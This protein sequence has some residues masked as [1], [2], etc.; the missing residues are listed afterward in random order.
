[1]AEFEQ[2]QLNTPVPGISDGTVSNPDKGPT[3]VPL[4]DASMENVDIEALENNYFT[5]PIGTL[6]PAN[7][8]VNNW[9]ATAQVI[10]QIPISYAPGINQELLPPLPEQNQ[11]TKVANIAEQNRRSFSN[12]LTRSQNHAPAYFGADPKPVH[13]STKGFNFDKWQGSADFQEV[14]FH[15]F[16]DNEALY[17]V[18]EDFWDRNSRMSDNYSKLYWPAFTSGWRAIGDMLSGERTYLE[19]DYLGAISF[20]DAMR[21][22]GGDWVNNTLLQTG[23]TMG[24]ISS[25]ALEELVLAGVTALSGGNPAVGGAAV[26]R[27]G[28]NVKR[29]FDIPK[30]FSRV[31]NNFGLTRAVSG[32]GA[33]LSSLR[34]AENA[35]DYWRAGLRF[36]AH[37]IAPETAAAWR[38]LNTTK[39]VANG[40]QGFGKGAQYFG[41]FYRDL[42]AVNLAVAES[43]LEGGMVFNEMIDNLYLEERAKLD[44][45]D[46]SME[47]LENVYKHSKEAEFQTVLYNAPVIFLTNKLVIGTALKGFKGL[48]GAMASAAG[49]MGRRVLTYAGVKTGKEA[50]KKG[51]KW[52]LPRVMARG[53]KG[54]MQQ[55]MGAGLLYGRANLAEGFQELYQEGLAV[56][57]K[58]YYTNLH[59]DNVIVGWDAQKASSEWSDSKGRGVDAMMTK[60]GAEIFASGFVMGGLVQMPQHIMFKTVP[61]T[62]HRITNNAEWTAQQEQQEANLDIAVE[63]L[64]EMYDDAAS[65][66][67]R[68]FDMSKLN[69]ATQKHLSEIMF[70]ADQRYS[71][72]EYY[73]AKDASIYS[74]LNS[75]HMTGKAHFFKAQ[76]QDFLELD[77]K[78]LAEAFPEES[79]Q[80]G[81]DKV[82]SRMVASVERIDTTEKAWKELNQELTN[83]F[84]RNKYKP[85]TD[86]YTYEYINEVMYNQFKNMMMFNTQMMK[87]AVERY[88]SVRGDLAKSG[89]SKNIQSK[90]IDLLTN[91]GALV[92]EMSMLEVE[93]EMART[94]EDLEIEMISQSEYKRLY[95]DIAER[96]Q[97]ELDK[98]KAAGKNDYGNVMKVQEK[99]DAEEATLKEREIFESE[100]TTGKTTGKTKE[101]RIEEL[102]KQ[103]EE[104]I[105]NYYKTDEEGASV[106]NPEHNDVSTQ[107]SESWLMQKDKTRAIKYYEALMK[108]DIS[109]QERHD[110]MVKWMKEKNMNMRK[111]LEY[112]EN[113][114]DRID[115]KYDKLIDKVKQEEEAEVVEDTSKEKTEESQTKTRIKSGEEL[116]EDEA[117]LQMAEDERAIYLDKQERLALLKEIFE[118]L[119][120]KENVIKTTDS[121]EVL[122]LIK[123][124][125]NKDD[126]LDEEQKKQEIARRI[127]EYEIKSVEKN[128]GFFDRRKVGKLAPVVQAYIE[129]LSKQEGGDGI[130][131]MTKFEDF[132]K[133]IM[134]YKALNGRSIELNKAIN[135]MIN[136]DHALEMQDRM[137]LG[138]LKAYRENRGKIEG[139][140]RNWIGTQSVNVFLNDLANAGIYP[141]DE[142]MEA[143]LKDPQNSIPRTYRTENGMLTK[144]TDALKY[145]QLNTIRINFKESMESLFKK[146]EKKEEKKAEKET[147]KKEVKSFQD[148]VEEEQV[149]DPV[150]KQE[151]KLDQRIKDAEEMEEGVDD[152]RLRVPSFIKT[153]LNRRHANY[154]R[155]WKL[156][157]TTEDYMEIEQWREQPKIKAIYKA[158]TEIY[159]I[160]ALE[161]STED[162]GEWL[163]KNRTTPQIRKIYHSQ[164][165]LTY[166]D[167]AVKEPKGFQKSTLDKGARETVLLGKGVNIIRKTLV[168]EDG[169][170]RY[171]YDITD[172]YKNSLILKPIEGEDALN[173]AK[174]KQQELINKSTEG[175]SF[176]FEGKA[177][178]HG[179]VI[180]DKEE[181]SWVIISKRDT[182]NGND[183]YITPIE[184]FKKKIKRKKV[185]KTGKFTSEGWTRSS[186]QSIDKKAKEKVSQLRPEE[187]LYISS[188]RKKKKDTNG[189]YKGEDN[190]EDIE[191]KQEADERQQTMLR[192]LEPAELAG[193]TLRISYGPKWAHAEGVT[194]DKKT[195]ADNYGKEYAENV[196]ILKH[197]QEYS[198][199]VLN[200]ETSLG[201]LNGPTS[202]I[203][204]DSMG[205][206]IHPEVI[207]ESQVLKLFRTYGN[208]NITKVTKDVRNHYIQAYYLYEQFNNALRGKGEDAAVDLKLSDLDYVDIKISRGNEAFVEKGTKG[209]KFEDLEYKY[210][211]GESTYWILQY[212]RDYSVTSGGKIKTLD[213]HITNVKRSQRKQYED[214][215]DELTRTRGNQL[216]KLGA[217]VA[218]VQLPNGSYSLI[219]VKAP[220]MSDEKANNIISSIHKQVEKTLDE[221]VTKTKD[222]K[223]K[224]KSTS[225]NH[226]FNDK[227][228]EDLFIANDVGTDVQLNVTPYG[229]LEI[230]LYNKKAFEKKDGKAAIFERK[231]LIKGEELKN[232][233]TARDLINYINKFSIDAKNFAKTQNDT[234][235]IKQ[236]D[237]IKLNLTVNAFKESIPDKGISSKQILTQ[238]LLPAETS[239]EK[240]VRKNIK[241]LMSASDSAGMDSTA[242]RLKTIRR[243]ANEGSANTVEKEVTWV[244]EDAET[245][246]L[247]PEIISNAYENPEAIPSAVIAGIVGKIQSGEGLNPGEANLYDNIA[248]ERIDEALARAEEQETMDESVKEE[249]RKKVNIAKQAAEDYY[250][251]KT[252]EIID[253]LVK[254]G[255]TS[256]QAKG[257]AYLT[258]MNDPVYLSLIEEYEDLN[259]NSALAVIPGVWDG[260]DVEK[261]DNFIA[262][263]KESLPEQLYT[264]VDHLQQIDELGIK[265]KEA[266]YKVGRFLMHGETISELQ[267]EISVG[268]YTPL[269]YHEAFHG[270]FRMLLTDQEI[271]HYLG[272]A[273]KEVR[274]KMTDGGITLTHGV[275]VKNVNDALKEMR[276]VHPKYVEMTRAKLEETLYE[277]YLANQFDNWKMNPQS[278]STE[279]RSLFQKIMDFIKHLLGY[280]REKSINDLFNEIDSGVFRTKATKNN[281]FTRAAES[282]S[283][284]TYRNK[285]VAFAIVNIPTGVITT[286]SVDTRTG[287]ERTMDVTSYIPADDAQRMIFTIGQLF[288]NRR[289]KSSIADSALLDNTISDFVNMYNVADRI[290]FY[291]E[292]EGFI[293]FAPKLKKYHDVLS[294]HHGL[295]KDAVLNYIGAFAV[296]ENENDIEESEEAQEYGLRST[297][298]YSKDQSMVGGWSKLSEWVRQYIGLTTLTE[299]DEYGNEFIN[300]EAPQ[301]LR[302]RVTVPVDFMFVYRG[303]LKSVKNSRN[304]QELIKKMVMFS[305]SDNKH[306]RAFVDKFLK[307]IGLTESEVLSDDWQLGENVKDA[308]KFQRV[309]NAFRL[310]RTT[311]AIVHRDV[312]GGR[313]SGIYYMYEANR[314]DDEHSQTKIWAA[315]FIQKAPRLL[316]DSELQREVIR[317]LDDLI[318]LLEVTSITDR[319]TTEQL[320]KIKN[321]DVSKDDSL[322]GRANYISSVLNEALGMSLRSEYIKYSVTNNIAE[323]DRTNQ[324]Q[325]LYTLNNYIE[326]VDTEAIREIKMSLQKGEH[327]YRDYQELFDEETGESLGFEKGG[328]KGRIRKLAANNAQFDESVGESTFMSADNHKIWSSQVPTFHL[329][330]I[331]EMR[332][333]EWIKKIQD[334]DNFTYDS[335]IK[336]EKFLEAVRRGEIR[337]IR[338]SGHKLA[339]LGMDT[340]EFELGSGNGV[341]YG[342]LSM[343]DFIKN[344]LAMATYTYDKSSPLKKTPVFETKD[345]QKFVMA[346]VPIKILSDAST[347][348]MVVMP[349][350]HMIHQTDEGEIELTDEG[351]DLYMNDI[352]EEYARIQKENDLETKDE[353]TIE[354]F[355]T[356]E[357]RGLQLFNTGN[358]MNIREG[359]IKSTIRVQPPSLA[360]VTI[361]GILEGNQKITLLSKAQSGKV[362]IAVGTTAVVE[363]IKRDKAGGEYV[364]ITNK[365]LSNVEDVDLAR[366]IEDLGTMVYRTRPE[367]RGKKEP[368][369]FT[370][371]K[372]K[373]WTFSWNLVNFVNGKQDFY[374]LRYNTNIE[375]EAGIIDPTAEYNISERTVEELTELRDDAVEREEYELA[376]QLTN[377]LDSRSKPAD[378]TIPFKFKE[379]TN[380]EDPTK[381]EE[382]A[383]I[384]KYNEG[385]EIFLHIQTYPKTPSSSQFD[386]LILHVEGQRIGNMDILYDHSNKIIA[387]KSVDAKYRATSEHKTI[388]NVE[389]LESFRGLGIG[390]SLYKKA[391]TKYGTLRSDISIGPDAFH[392]YE[393]LVKEGYAEKITDIEQIEGNVGTFLLRAPVEQD[394]SN[395]L[396]TLD[397]SVKEEMEERALAGMPWVVASKEPITYTDANGKKITTTLEERVKQKQMQELGDFT[398]MLYEQNVMASLPIDVREGL[399]DVD[400]NGTNGVT[401]STTQETDYLEKLYNIKH[402]NREYNLAQLFFNFSINARKFAKHTT[403]D[404]AMSFTDM[405][406]NLTK[407]AKGEHGGGT[408]FATD[409]IAPELGIHHKNKDINLLTIRD[410]KYQKLYNDIFGT[411]DVGSPGKTADAFA[412]MTTK[413][414]LHTAFG[415]GRLS[416]NQAQL[417]KKISNG[418]KISSSEI[419]GDS[420]FQGGLIL[421]IGIPGSGKSTWINKLRSEGRNVLVISPDAIRAELTD[422]SDQS[423]N[424]LVFKLAHERA[425]TG[426]RQGKLVVFDATNTMQEGPF[427]RT[428]LIE[429]LKKMSGKEFTTYYEMFDVDIAT[430]KE[431]IKN[432]IATGKKRANV[433]EHVVDRMYTQ[434][435]ENK[436]NLSGMIKFDIAHVQN[437]GLKKLD[438]FLNSKKFMYYDGTTYLK[439]SVVAL[440]PELTSVKIDGEWVARIGREEWHDLRLKLE[441][442]EVDTETFS[443]AAF[444]SASKMAKINVVDTKDAFSKKD[445]S[446]MFTTI[447]A[448]H[449][450]RQMINPS[451]KME[452]VDAVQMKHK[453]PSEQIEGKTIKIDNKSY[454]IREV[455]D[456]YH[457]TIQARLS[458]KYFRR[459]NLIFTMESSLNELA[460][461]KEIGKATV[462]LKAFVDYAQNALEASQAKV[463]MLDLFETENGTPK[464]NLNN[465]ITEKQFEKLFLTFFSKG[466]LSERLPGTSLAL[467]PE[468]GF[469]V[470]KKVVELDKETGQPIRW[471]IIRSD[472]WET[473]YRPKGVEI[474]HKEFADE[475]AETFTNGSMKEGDIYLDVLRHDVM[476]YN[477]K[478]E[479]TDVTGSEF[480]MSPHFKSVMDHIKPGDKIPD[481]IAKAFGIRIPS[482]DD[483]SA[484]NLIMVDFLP[485]VYGSTAIF[486]KRL[487]EISGADFDIDKLYTQL[488]EFYHEKGVFKEYGKGENRKQQ[489]VD[490]IRNTITQYGNKK[491]DIFMATEV[492]ADRGDFVSAITERTITSFN[493]EN[494]TE[495]TVEEILESDK[496]VTAFIA[497]E[498]LE[499]SDPLT[500]Q[501]VLKL[502]KRNE[503]IQGGL[504]LIGLPSTLEEYNQYRDEYGREPY[505]AALNNDALDLKYALLG[506]PGKTQAGKGDH[507]AP[508]YQSAVVTPLEEAWDFFESQMPMLS[509]ERKAQEYDPYNLLGQAVAFN[510]NKEFSRGIG[511]IVA[512]NLPLNVLSE[513]NTKL[514]ND[515]YIPVLELNGQPYKTFVKKYAI[516]TETGEEDS[517]LYRKQFAIS[518]LISGI[519]DNANEQLAQKLGIV[520]ESL[521]VLGTL[522]AMGV[523]MNTA[524]VFIN[525]PAINLIYEELGTKGKMEAGFDKRLADRIN[526]IQKTVLKRKATDKETKANPEVSTEEM[527]KFINETKINR[528][529]GSTKA[530]Y[531]KEAKGSNFEVLTNDQ[532][533]FDLAVLEEFQKA[534][535]YTDFVRNVGVMLNIAKGTGQDTAAIEDAYDAAA[536]LGL[537][538]NNKEFSKT[539][540]PFDVRS[541]FNDGKTFQSTYWQILQEI[542]EKVLPKVLLNRT[543]PFLRLRD[544][545][546]NNLNQGRINSEQRR[547]L[548]SE[549]T[550]YL[551]GKAY[552]QWLKFDDTH[553]DQLA[554]LSNGYIYDALGEEFTVISVVDRMRRYLT[555]KGRENYFLN[556]H[557]VAIDTKHEDNKQGF[558][559]LIT[560]NWTQFTD[561]ELNNL[562]SS[563]L[564]LYSDVNTRQDLMHLINYLTV[565]D[566]LRFNSES[567]INVVPASLLQNQLNVVTPV[568]KLFLDSKPSDKLYDRI[569]GATYKELQYELIVGFTEGVNSNKFITQINSK[570]LDQ[571]FVVDAQ[572]AIIPESTININY[573]A[574]E[575]ESNTKLLSNLAERKFKY[576]FK[577][578]TKEYG[579]VEHAFQSL[580]SGEFDQ[581]TYDKYKKKDGYGI[582]IEGKETSESIDPLAL[583]REL[584]ITSFTQN[585]L[586]DKL[587]KM[588]M[589]HSNF[590][591]SQG[592]TVIDR[593]MLDGL[594]MAQTEFVT[595]KESQRYVTRGYVK[596]TAKHASK[597]VNNRTNERLDEGTLRVNTLFELGKNSMFANG[598]PLTGKKL[599]ALNKTKEILE[600]LGIGYTVSDKK[601]RPR[602]NANFPYALTVID[603]DLRGNKEYR[604]YKLEGMIQPGDGTI[605]VDMFDVMN[606]NGE[607]LGVI[608]EYVKYDQLGSRQQKGPAY[609]YGQRPTYKQ[610]RQN[611]EDKAEGWD[612]LVLGIGENIGDGFEEMFDF[613]KRGEDKAF[614]ETDDVTSTD[615][616]Y[617]A[618]EKQGEEQSEDPIESTL[619]TDAEGGFEID[620]RR[621]VDL[622]AI[623]NKTKDTSEQT[624]DSDQY[625]LITEYFTNL[626]G[627][628]K[629]KLMDALDISTINELFTIFEDQN[630]LD[631][632]KQFIDRLKSCY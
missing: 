255:Q 78:A 92:K 261:I 301:H 465:P 268:K 259:S 146:E 213:R 33:L 12:M 586:N 562:Q 298:Q 542:N 331:A 81:V 43:K 448:K 347:L 429:N 588:L 328:V 25:I 504:W 308:I 413:A 541:I 446:N 553:A 24:I 79:N 394:S 304:D 154:V 192:N 137:A 507:V 277:E 3:A 207:T 71:A 480:M 374:I 185:I 238:Y 395:K 342:D 265:L 280:T 579:S 478:G 182:F 309:V 11:K 219:E 330:T 426:L 89:V 119:T 333:N 320:S 601:G 506:N 383:L 557:I 509:E 573:Y 14:G 461:S 276:K 88:N 565:K 455:M 178:K 176:E 558:S 143:F 470:V 585:H 548:S 379:L 190:L 498:I 15:P 343:K 452:I 272:L 87:R 200:G 567:F 533:L 46:P 318:D 29:A 189:Y 341:S 615:K 499:I 34:K 434:F 117:M 273:K 170:E 456:K 28:I 148:F 488:K 367:A 251:A 38:T 84:D 256:A 436:D 580:R 412:V 348:D 349:V 511:S 245:E 218:V 204:L 481:V 444:E 296:K 150:K 491:S 291:Q 443:M 346:P 371:R 587:I 568:H 41:A 208:Q 487:I 187:P 5:F 139:R 578:K 67:G 288:M 313:E 206:A 51:S 254:Q 554:S 186:D 560:S 227:L 260:Y 357:M 324:Q 514:R 614:S 376:Q 236:A 319:L 93:M 168:D 355:N 503:D 297:S 363:L 368:L 10:N 420:Q 290:E 489:Y 196:N 103:R 540:I 623:L 384:K 516:N 151:E 316:K 145:S 6:S 271:K 589:G 50:I 522:V 566:G 253:E 321:Y 361:E 102:N 616:G 77:D 173:K 352:Q 220:T 232:I 122:R 228:G 229:E 94:T 545:L 214:I 293:Q 627:V 358:L 21:K 410:H 327:L 622:D 147:V 216:A 98:L 269:K 411:G 32:G 521:P 235:L 264:R 611:E 543:T 546:L 517:K 605:N 31:Y 294:E 453:L 36:G 380:Q 231:R 422:V 37:M 447:Q 572:E 334:D 257:A 612:D 462:N 606:D 201:Y 396:Y 305:R 466:V 445:V 439:M 61:S 179:E 72:L 561:E 274:A 86:E 114:I 598:K 303:I 322:E 555:N 581:K 386:T 501:Q 39:N 162:F 337:H 302:E 372:K 390:K 111:P 35:K 75:L 161:R 69:S 340:G 592:L 424:A 317:A 121:K 97:A 631:N 423:N 518:S 270:V 263:A 609:L 401:Y 85:G 419:F 74:H 519:V 369:S 73:D 552:I 134:D 158:L 17:K 534:K 83:P 314:Q 525:H 233:K 160:Y 430:V 590:T 418:D 497:R 223:V 132:M 140:L 523:D 479:P 544:S 417:I 135:M 599:S 526:Y 90:D 450:R 126:S 109:H 68:Y 279:T 398:N 597:S 156:S 431:R 595:N 362:R 22:G 44:G 239:Y 47:A 345:G 307:D 621:F 537:D 630:N 500:D 188:T 459:R 624:D 538:L 365:G 166:T 130:V 49:G 336:D 575:G 222:D 129:Y 583:M 281:M 4:H 373:F 392:V 402:G 323:E 570:K 225:F 577:G 19:G 194:V 48:A 124:K 113:E 215:V 167:I 531:V 564:E 356:G 619:E 354:G 617:I 502:W 249:Y 366:V 62:F 388:V 515:E 486:S 532:A 613:T 494:G 569:F 602:I 275:V 454:S 58:D 112:N 364:A 174:K 312:R 326:A 310:Y 64:Q 600:D 306:T 184:D 138:M 485:A 267:G 492:W 389:L 468:F 101:E 286:S 250:N 202:L 359:N 282:S 247:T 399:I 513:H 181:N 191:T 607:F 243:L 266:K 142:E 440:I 574:E 27:T 131:D 244:E 95:Q 451:N 594:R 240:R 527:V 437:K 463:Q 571:S 195:I 338:L 474:D 582:I 495:Y 8:M 9:Q 493:K 510:S 391:V 381:A 409:I 550:S 299:V 20:H 107:I 246:E 52:W 477:E 596:D 172:D 535:A 157:D 177:F 42:R 406:V 591:I 632:E 628:D 180:E 193:L 80:D 339:P 471:D 292:Q 123:A 205:T 556:E 128:F 549:I 484:V 496:K 625:P 136:P 530:G 203:L 475:V 512:P 57:M 54:N 165:A 315:K 278:V 438:A 91:V 118:V 224:P 211:D 262:W 40:I 237:K 65:G 60:Q 221:N 490:Y 59:N 608:A 175:G 626:S 593:A 105:T 252:N 353:R 421:P 620:N 407:R 528:T 248:K 13:F 56:S 258:V 149:D 393:S 110:R 70:E 96:R 505:D 104:E 242:D 26:A 217:Y 332:G 610:L 335:L 230:T 226:E 397:T 241:L 108:L 329:E 99:Y 604:H 559:R 432:D 629:L 325:A 289:E 536:E 472:D 405:F 435:I 377:E 127:F 212:R 539:N 284:N 351:V 66:V 414:A 234:A 152:N 344:M 144:E 155:N 404:A 458:N 285:P 385:S 295:I 120:N 45:G 469:K 476:I 467:M 2:D 483:H 551:A 198:V 311:N 153:V 141:I 529:S 427:G 133:G 300:P 442:K 603:E 210:I 197:A 457:K 115:D 183:L 7:D 18:S 125:V 375:G 209:V 428:A 482:Q 387:D 23:F 473:N 76:F 30:Y 382:K 584:V 55:I 425:A 403:G 400:T 1:M 360:D 350:N 106:A 508:A 63:H 164:F 520:K 464:Y 449:L 416:W 441:A 287:E 618:I 283:G 169:N 163:E 547:V 100:E 408:N 116:T 199:E 171:M 53:F 378:S 460:K 433:P 415:D 16:R 576:D 563:M 370:Y 524:L 159:K 82:R